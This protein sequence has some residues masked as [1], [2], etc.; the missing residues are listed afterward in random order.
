MC[1]HR[2]NTIFE[3]V[4]ETSYPEEKDVAS[5]DDIIGG[6]VFIPSMSMVF[7]RSAV[8]EIPEWFTELWAGHAPLILLIT[9]SG[10]NY[11]F[12][13]SMGVKRKNP[14]SVSRNKSFSREWKVSNR[15][16]CYK[17]LNKHFEY[18]RRR[19][20][21]PVI[22]SSYYEKLGFDL[23]RGKI[24]SVISDVFYYLYYLSLLLAR[25]FYA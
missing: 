24:L 19:S 8:P 16:Y 22:L 2:V 5:F 7:R 1:S 18:K 17:K 23:K 20:I 12:P 6:G 15:I 11:H 10:K 14:G 3:G 4:K 21:D 13:D 25:R 9:N